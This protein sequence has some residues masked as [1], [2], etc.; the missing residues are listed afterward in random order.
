M[1]LKLWNYQHNCKLINEVIICSNKIKIIGFQKNGTLIYCMNS[2]CMVCVTIN[3]IDYN[4][5]SLLT[6]TNVTEDMSQILF[7]LSRTITSK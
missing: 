7:D 3:M 6:A 4:R 5:I 1:T 2:V